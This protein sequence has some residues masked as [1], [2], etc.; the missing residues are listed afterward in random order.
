MLVD[1][2]VVMDLYVQKLRIDRWAYLRR[3]ALPTSCPSYILKYD[4]VMT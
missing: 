4:V 2:A 3:A 1:G